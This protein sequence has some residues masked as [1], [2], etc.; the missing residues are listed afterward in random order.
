ME[1]KTSPGEVILA[2]FHWLQLGSGLASK[3]RE[4]IYVCIMALV[5]ILSGKGKM[6][7]IQ[8]KF[9]SVETVRERILGAIYSHVTVIN[10]SPGI[11][12]KN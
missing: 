10:L 1:R 8:A 5:Y 11:K 6:K 3:Q 12:K 2:N 7:T 4:N 9:I